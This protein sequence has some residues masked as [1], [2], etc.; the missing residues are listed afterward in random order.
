M[1]SAIPTLGYQ[2]RAAAALALKSKGMRPTEIGKLIGL[3]GRQVGFALQTKKRATLQFPRHM[4]EM[5]E[6]HAERRGI[7]VT[8]LAI[9]IVFAAAE[10]DMIDAILDDGG[11]AA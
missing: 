6:P 9:A 1:P 5:L 3:T 7:S 2:S 4:I 8:A 11:A 10:D